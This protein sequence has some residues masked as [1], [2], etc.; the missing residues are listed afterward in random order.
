MIVRFLKTD[1]RRYAVTVVTDQG[2]E[3]SMPTGPGSDPLM[4]HDLQH[5][6]VEQEFGWK[7]AIF[8]QLALGGDAGTFHKQKTGLSKRQLSRQRRAEKKKSSS[9]ASLGAE[10]SARSER[11]TYICLHRWMK[12]SSHKRLNERAAEIE[13]SIE[14][15]LKFMDKD[16]RALYTP[17][18][19]ESVVA[20]MNLLS[21]Q[22]ANT[23]V[24]SHM[25]VRWA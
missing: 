1:E 8:G 6:I 25:D 7:H 19:L 20:K 5:L 10:E 15:A 16:E 4:P 24:G 9:L 3:M 14:S 13:D 23:P 2:E 18:R 17:A 22:W 11:A 21:E 12:A